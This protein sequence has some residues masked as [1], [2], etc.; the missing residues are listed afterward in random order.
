MGQV[1]VCNIEVEACAIAGQSGRRPGV[2]ARQAE[3]T[4]VGQLGKLRP[5]GNR[6]T[7][8]LA[9]DGAGSGSTSMPRTRASR[10]KYLRR[11]LVW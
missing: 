7:G 11:R 9:R 4:V 10:L 3:G 6:P 5:I 1:G 2:W 8:T